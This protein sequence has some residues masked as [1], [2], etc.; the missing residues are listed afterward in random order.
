M[1]DTHHIWAYFSVVSSFQIYYMAET[2]KI[3][4]PY[5]SLVFASGKIFFCSQMSKVSIFFVAFACIWCQFSSHLSQ[6]NIHFFREKGRND[7]WNFSSEKREQK[8]GAVFLRMNFNIDSCL[9]AYRKQ[10]FCIFYFE[11]MTQ[12]TST[13]KGSLHIHSVWL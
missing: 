11:V 5:H 3:C 9:K 7:A 6:K 4:Y 13:V 10:K 12:L 8:N 1:V 2:E